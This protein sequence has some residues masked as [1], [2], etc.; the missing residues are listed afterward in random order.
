MS[1][2]T[3]WYQIVVPVGPEREL[4][5]I[6]RRYVRNADRLADALLDPEV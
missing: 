6:H 1:D 2:E 4:S 5:A 3:S